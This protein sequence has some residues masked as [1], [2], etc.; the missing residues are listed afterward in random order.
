[1]YRI[2]EGYLISVSFEG[3]VDICRIQDVL[4]LWWLDMV[5]ERVL[6]IQLTHLKSAYIICIT[7]KKC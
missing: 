6:G 3:K 4:L 7:C 1:V 2:L 5:F